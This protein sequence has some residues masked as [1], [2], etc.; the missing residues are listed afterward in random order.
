MFIYIQN[1]GWGNL[2]LTPPCIISLNVPNFFDCY[3]LLDP[4][5]VFGAVVFLEWH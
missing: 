5:C 1:L 4:K 3:L 2:M